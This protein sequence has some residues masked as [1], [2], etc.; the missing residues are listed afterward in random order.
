MWERVS[1]EV[2][3]GDEECMDVSVIT[4]SPAINVH[5]AVGNQLLVYIV[6]TIC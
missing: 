4:L 1:D 2:V 6:F 5:L 3:T